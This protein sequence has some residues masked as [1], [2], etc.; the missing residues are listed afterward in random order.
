MLIASLRDKGKHPCP[1]CL[2]NLK[3]IPNIGTE[4]DRSLR[5]T[6]ARKDDRFLNQL[7]EEA[8]HL[9]YDEGYAVNLEKV[10]S[11]LKDISTVPTVVSTHMLNIH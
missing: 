6:H 10:Q 5:N 9:I 8:R 11:L 1:H 4:E 3:G 2:I 7:V